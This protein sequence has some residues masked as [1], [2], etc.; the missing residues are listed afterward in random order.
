MLVLTPT[1]QLFHSLPSRRSAKRTF[2][3]LPSCLWNHIKAPLF[4]VTVNKQ[5]MNPIS[6]DPLILPLMLMPEGEQK[7]YKKKLG[8][9]YKEHQIFRMVLN[10]RT[11]HRAEKIDDL[12]E[13]HD[14]HAL[15]VTAI[16]QLEFDFNL[17]KP[18]VPVSAARATIGIT[19]LP[20][21]LGMTRMTTRARECGA[22]C[23][24]SG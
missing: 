2:R 18:Q 24:A 3:S 1:L 21:D 4:S 20:C 12:E 15:G 10:I 13:I 17:P 16:A 14:Y 5:F 8:T 11:V 6:C 23:A 9:T 19:S 22:A 7:T